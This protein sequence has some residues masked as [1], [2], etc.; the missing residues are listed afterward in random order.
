VTYTRLRQHVNAPRQ[1]VYGAIVD[2]HAVAIWMVPHGM[3]SRVRA[4]DAREGGW[5]RITLTY[6]APNG[7]GKT[8]AR[9]D[10]LVEAS[11]IG[12]L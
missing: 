2:A 3:T 11:T 9:T 5:L 7:T 12:Y 4:F 8:T 10:T 6:D 1:S